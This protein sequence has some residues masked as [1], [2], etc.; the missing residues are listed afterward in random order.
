MAEIDDET[1][2][3]LEDIEVEHD[4]MIMSNLPEKCAT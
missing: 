4:S 3:D 1:D 2:E